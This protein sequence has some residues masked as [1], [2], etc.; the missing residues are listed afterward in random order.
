MF[1]RNVQTGANVIWNSADANTPHA[2]MGVTNLNWDVA[3]VGDFDGDGRADVFW[4]NVAT[5]A[6]V[7]WR[8]GSASS[9]Q[10]ITGVG[11]LAWGIVPMRSQPLSPWDY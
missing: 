11:D 2:T 1:W 4:R 10:S 3:T 7:I 9:A 6:N 8:A 5:G